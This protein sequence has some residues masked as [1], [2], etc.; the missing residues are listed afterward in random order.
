MD[1]KHRPN[2]EYKQKRTPSITY[3]NLQNT[4]HVGCGWSQ[5]QYRGFAVSI[6]VLLY[7]VHITVLMYFVLLYYCSTYRCITYH[8]VSLYHNITVSQYHCITVF[9]LILYESLQGYFE[10]FLVCNYGPSANI[11]KVIVIVITLGKASTTP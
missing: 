6:T 5:F 1:V 9:T 11:W 7:F 4:T 3:C 10:N 8:T 2:I